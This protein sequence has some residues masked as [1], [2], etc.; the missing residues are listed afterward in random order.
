MHKTKC[1]QNLTQGTMVA[2]RVTIADTFLP[3]LAGLLGKRR[4]DAGCGLLLKPSSGVHTIGMLFAIDVVALD[5]DMQV[6]RLWENLVPYRVT[7]VSLKFRTVLELPAG[8][9]RNCQL[10][11][12]D[13]L[14]FR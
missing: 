10:R 2:E 11:I 12:G 13:Q 4:L 8:H 14:A 3:R 9:I 6:L 1:L 5:A 7:A